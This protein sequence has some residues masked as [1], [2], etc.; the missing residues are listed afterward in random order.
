MLAMLAMLI[1]LWLLL[2]AC[3]IFHFT[4]LE[5]RESEVLNRLGLVD[6]MAVVGEKRGDKGLH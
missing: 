5:C 2:K 3:D 6:E 1:E 4:P